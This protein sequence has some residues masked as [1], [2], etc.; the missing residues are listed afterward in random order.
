MITTSPRSGGVRHAPGASRRGRLEVS[1]S[2]G[3]HVAA[4]GVLREDVGGLGHVLH[5]GAA[6]PGPAV[7]FATGLGGEVLGDIFR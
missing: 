7:G 1:Q 6:V 3:G 4:R 5:A 2:A